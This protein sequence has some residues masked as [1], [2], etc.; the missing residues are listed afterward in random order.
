MKAHFLALVLLALRVLPAG[1]QPPRAPVPEQYTVQV[2]YQIIAQRDQFIAVYKRLIA[3]LEKL[4]FEFDPPLDELPVTHWED[5]GRNVLRGR[6]AGDRVTKLLELPGVAQLLLV[7]SDFKLPE[8]PDA[9]VQVQ[10]DLVPRLSPRRQLELLDQVRAVLD[11]LGFREMTGYD[12]RGFTGQPHTRLRGTIATSQLDT[13]LKDL[14]SQPTGWFAPRIP[15]SELPEPIRT[16]NPVLITTVIA[17]PAPVKPPAW[18]PLPDDLNLLKLAPEL[19]PLTQL[20]DP[21]RIPLRVEMLLATPPPEKDDA[22]AKP[23]Y[24]A[25]PSLVIEGQQGQIISATFGVPFVDPQRNQLV[26][27]PLAVKNQLR[28]LA[29]LPQ[30]TNIR[31]ITPPRGPV[32]PVVKIEADNQR[33]LQQTGLASLHKKGHRGQ[34]VRLAI[35]DADF[36]GWE[37]MV[38]AG[39]LGKKTRLVDLTVSRNANLYP[40]PA[41]PGE[42]LGHGTQLALAAQLAAPEAEITLVRSDPFAPYLLEEIRLLARGDIKLTPSL[43]RRFDE[44][45]VA[46]ALLRQRRAEV[47]AERRLVLDNFEDETD[48][49]FRYRILGPVR[50][51]LFTTREWHHARMSE[52]EREDQQLREREQRLV[53]QIEAVGSLRGIDIVCC[54]WI[55][56]SG[57]PHG[58][59]SYLSRLFDSEPPQLPGAKAAPLGKRPRDG[60][61]SPLWVQSAGNF[62]GQ[63]WNDYLRDDDGDGVMEFAGPEAK[64]PPQRWTR[65]LNFLAWQSYDGKRVE[66]I[67]EKTLARLSLQWTEPHEPD[68]YFRQG[69]EDR[70]ARPLAELRVVVLRQRDPTGQRLSLDDFEVVAATTGQP[71]RID[72]HPTSATYEM[73]LSWKVDKPGRYAVRITRQVPARWIVANEPR[74]GGLRFQLLQGLA[75]TGIRPVG[76]PTLPEFERRWE[77]RPVLLV[78]AFLAPENNPGRIILADF[79]TDTGTVTMPADARQVITTAAAGWDGQPRFYSSVGPPANQTLARWPCLLAPDGLQLGPTAA[80]PAFGSSISAAFTAGA[81]AVQLSR[82]GSREQLLEAFAPRTPQMLRLPD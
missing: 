42:G 1:T 57:Y 37:K 34:G 53:R 48:A 65:E 78:E 67:P 59:R 28:A 25:A 24:R 21:L 62:R 82:G 5:P 43:T 19:L 41:A 66:E 12:Q 49:K 32:D 13:L 55:W 71:Q 3:G 60:A 26:I 69:E 47:L 45:A 9:P 70:Y 64:L 54:P 72:N 58:N 18:P 11:K 33:A 38:T 40:D 76:V 68:Y 79:H 16:V 52:V 29:A 8:Q 17:D 74:T 61:R 7:P 15:A 46:A 63:V 50:W 20:D 27:P 4:G 73:S 39:S 80:G 30:I 2:R 36:R 77:L 35:I 23:L 44:V 10:L 56:P 75:P 31:L 14:R 51:W 81:V 6:L 22:W